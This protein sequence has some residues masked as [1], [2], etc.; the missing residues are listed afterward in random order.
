ML[1]ASFSRCPNLVANA[2]MCA[3][4]CASKTAKHSTYTDASFSFSFGERQHEAVSNSRTERVEPRDVHASLD[5]SR[6]SFFC[7]M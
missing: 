3:K 6:V 7:H 1:D 5:G 4:N 2:D